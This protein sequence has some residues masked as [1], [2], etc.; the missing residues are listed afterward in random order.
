LPGGIWNSYEKSKKAEL[1]KIQK[2][3]E[4]AEQILRYWATVFLTALGVCCPWRVPAGYDETAAR[5]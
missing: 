3:V 5:D 1:G 2:S 4:F